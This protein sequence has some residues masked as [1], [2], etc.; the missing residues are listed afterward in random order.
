MEKIFWAEKALERGANSIA[1]GLNYLLSDIAG[2]MLAQVRWHMRSRFTDPATSA[3]ISIATPRAS[4]RG[5]TLIEIVVVM[6]IVAILVGAAY[7]SYHETVLKGGRMDA[8]SSLLRIQLAQARYRTEHAS[9][10]ADLDDLGW[11][12]PYLSERGYYQIELDK[13]VNPAFGFRATAIPAPGSDQIDDSCGLF[14]I[15]ANGPDRLS[16][17]AP[18]C[19]D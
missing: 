5:H 12:T 1:A 13:G 15:D 11:A 14:I 8:T 9:Y 7:P 6:A 10:S 16:S 18:A 17:S 2:V 4:H 3:P 19:W